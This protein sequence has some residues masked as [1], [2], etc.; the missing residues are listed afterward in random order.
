MNTI[1][2]LLKYTTDFMTNYTKS[3]KDYAIHFQQVFIHR[4]NLITAAVHLGKVERTFFTESCKSRTK[5]IVSEEGG[6]QK[7]AVTGTPFREKS[8][9]I[10]V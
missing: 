4:W 1:N 10:N 3:A 8:L 6:E 9:I 5:E 2:T 7:G